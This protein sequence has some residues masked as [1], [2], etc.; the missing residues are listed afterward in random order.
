M[1][2]PV[3]FRGRDLGHPRSGGD[4]DLMLVEVCCGVAV[5][6]GGQDVFAG[7]AL[8]G[9]EDADAFEQFD[10]RAGAFGEEGV[11][12]AGAF[13]AGDGAG[14]DHGGEVGVELLGAA[15]ELVAVHAGH[16][17]VAEQEIEGAGEGIG[18][19][20]QGFFGAGNGVDFIAAAGFEEKGSDRENLFIVVDAEDGFFRA[21]GISV[22]PAAT[23]GGAA[24]RMGLACALAGWPTRRGA[25]LCVPAVRAGELRSGGFGAASRRAE[26]REGLALERRPE[27]AELSHLLREE[28]A[29]R[30]PD[31]HMPG[32]RTAGAREPRRHRLPRGFAGNAEALGCGRPGESGNRGLQRVRWRPGGRFDCCRGERCAGS[33]NC[34][35]VASLNSS[36]Q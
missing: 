27:K 2:H 24:W 8:A 16:E 13:E 4:G 12:A 32:R 14:D 34:E 31:E 10:W 7:A 29:P 35:A 36:F 28:T 21:H 6:R 18:D 5:R 19:D 23:V 17:E 20:L 30:P 26:G 3:C 15:D 1:G 25:A 9:D 11:G 22:L 33:R